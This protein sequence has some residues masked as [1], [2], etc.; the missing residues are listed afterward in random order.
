MLTEYRHIPHKKLQG[1]PPLNMDKIPLHIKIA[2]WL[3]IIIFT[4]ISFYWFMQTLK[5][6]HPLIV[7]AK[8]LTSVAFLLPPSLSASILVTRWLSRHTARSVYWPGNN[9][10]LLPPDYSDVRS[11][12]AKGDY[13]KAIE[14]LETKIE[15]EP[16]NHLPVA[17]LSDIYIDHLNKNKEAMILLSN[18]LNKSKRTEDDVPLVMKLVDVL[19]EIDEP[20][21]ANKLLQGELTMNYNEQERRSLIKRLNGIEQ[22]NSNS[23][24]SPDI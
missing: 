2:Y 1:L 10:N 13:F 11:D 3:I 17:L 12:I 22:M 21:K 23:S 4:P 20:Q 19:L 18:Y 7:A 24:E 16:K 5:G 14:K 9:V 8:F 6:G 15:E